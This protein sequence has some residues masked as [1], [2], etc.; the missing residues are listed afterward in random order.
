MVII[1]MMDRYYRF[2]GKRRLVD[3]M[4]PLGFKAEYDLWVQ[5]SVKRDVLMFSRKFGNIRVYIICL[6]GT[7]S[8][9][10]EIRFTLSRRTLPDGAKRLLEALEAVTR[11]G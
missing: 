3:A 11:G 1:V 4:E 10:A 7:R 6:A 9:Q 8:C 5:G 2:R